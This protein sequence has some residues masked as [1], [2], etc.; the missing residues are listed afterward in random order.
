M[1]LYIE[2]SPMTKVLVIGIGIKKF[3]SALAN[4]DTL[5]RTQMSPRLPARATFV[6]DKNF[7]SG[8]QKYF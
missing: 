3:P 4:E 1:D 2:L 8:T 6:A 5:L 7:V